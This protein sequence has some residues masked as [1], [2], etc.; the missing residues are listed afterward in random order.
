MSPH[1]RAAQVGISRLRHEIATDQ[2][3]INRQ[4]D[5]INQII[6]TWHETSIER[7]YLVF[8]AAAIHAYYTGL[9]TLIE[10]IARQLDQNVPHGDKWHKSLITQA[11]IEL[12]EVRPAILPDH[13]ERDL[14]ALLSF[15]H[16]FRHAYGL[17]LEPKFVEEEAKRILRIHPEIQNALQSFIAFLAATEN[18]ITALSK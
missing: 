18:A 13:L 7:P 2:R 12:P 4:A 10:R 14:N 5:D 6:D 1:E 16:F 11:F 15:R 9:E 17:E 8:L 3:L